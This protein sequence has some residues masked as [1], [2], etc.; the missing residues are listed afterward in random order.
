MTPRPPAPE[1]DPAS[2]PAAT[3]GPVA[4]DTVAVGYDR[5][6]DRPRAEALAERLGLAVAK[7][8]NDPRPL[9]LAYAP[10]PRA[11][12]APSRP[13]ARP[14]DGPAPSGPLELRVV[15]EG[16]PLGGGHGVSVQLTGLDTTSPA[17]RSRKSPLHRAAGLGR[18]GASGA[19]PT[20]VLDATA[21]LG[22][23]AWLLAA[24]G[25]R[26]TALERHP[27]VH[28]LLADGL[29]RARAAAPDVAERITLLPCGEAADYLASPDAAAGGYDVVLLDPMFPEA[30]KRKTAERKPMRVLRW[31]A[32]EDQDADSLW[33]AA[34][35]AARRRVAVKRPRH[36]PD[37]AGQPPV[38]RHAGRGVRFDVYPVTNP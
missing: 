9:R 31:L 30:A 6:A 14:V 16:H 33:P 19:S 8:F 20:T 26:V 1:T 21:G 17:G 18:R 28:A 35:A 13:R 3:S 29:A 34:V 37:L 24:A 25:C 23:D 36:A 2:R 38:A 11:A 4:R 12:G 7:K 10:P 27:V 15:A 5:P 32:G 22:E